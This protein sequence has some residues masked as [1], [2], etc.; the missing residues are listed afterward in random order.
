MIDNHQLIIGRLELRAKSR[1]TYQALSGE[2]N[3]VGRYKKCA[4]S[5][6][7]FPKEMEYPAL[8]SPGRIGALII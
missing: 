8:S 3:T 6:G 4:L 1:K 5:R 2:C 7:N